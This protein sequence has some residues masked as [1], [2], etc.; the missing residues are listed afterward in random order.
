MGSL[1]EMMV[2]VAVVTT[3]VVVVVTTEV[4]IMLMPVKEQPCCVVELV[5]DWHPRLQN[6][7]LQDQVKCYDELDPVHHSI[8]D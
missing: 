5:S 8:V 2:V 1:V 7:G 4:A 6:R 3:A